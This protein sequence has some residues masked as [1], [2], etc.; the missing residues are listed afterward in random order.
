MC[1]LGNSYIK[2]DDFVEWLDANDMGD[3]P[4]GGEQHKIGIRI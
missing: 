1:E 3:L 4:I 2:G